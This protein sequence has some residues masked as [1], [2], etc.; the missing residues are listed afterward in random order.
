LKK[1]FKNYDVVLHH[2]A[3]RA[4]QKTVDNP[5]AANKNNI[6]G[7]LNVL[8]A[9]RECQIKK[10]VFAS[11]SA[12]YGDNF[13][14]KKPANRA[15][16]HKNRTQENQSNNETNAPNPLSPYALSKLAGEHYCRLFW[17]LY[18]LPTICLRYFNVYGPY[19][20]P[21]S[22]YSAVIPIFVKQLLTNKRPKIYGTGE[23]SRDFVY[24]DDVV[25]SNIL[26]LKSS[27]NTFGHVF[28]IGAG[29]A[30]TVN[31][32]FKILQ[33]ILKKNDIEPIYTDPLPGDVSKT[34]ADINKAKKMLGFKPQIKIKEGLRR[35]AGWYKI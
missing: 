30:I 18:G 27:K 13:S 29:G 1:E 7:T 31:K 34:E 22:K 8:T 5:L 23:Q 35:Y 10:V 9:A 16:R 20:N 3:M 4:V 12:I 2:A 14:T 11:S 28:N 24:I 15:G 6:T 17:Q 19:Q 33:T 32:L 21:E 26:A 25:Q